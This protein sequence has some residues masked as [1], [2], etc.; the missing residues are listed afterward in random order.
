MFIV[1]NPS[2]NPNPQFPSQVHATS[3]NLGTVDHNSS[4]NSYMCNKN[5]TDYH[6]INVNTSKRERNNNSNSSAWR[7]TPDRQADHTKIQKLGAITCAA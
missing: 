1:P 6:N 3:I 5:T 4:Y 7:V 2:I